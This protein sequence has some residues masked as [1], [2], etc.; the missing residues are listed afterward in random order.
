MNI[1][2]LIKSFMDEHP[3]INPEDIVEFKIM[4]NIKT[5]EPFFR[6]STAKYL[7]IWYYARENEETSR[8][9]FWLPIK[10]NY[11]IETDS[12]IYNSIHEMMRLGQTTKE[13]ACHT[14]FTNAK[15]NKIYREIVTGILSAKGVNLDEDYDEEWIENVKES[16]KIHKPRRN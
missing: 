6:V 10:Q 4:T 16:A 12:D 9:Y 3:D 13:I 15:V 8:V 11:L 5:M 1:F 14:G 2:E 7:F